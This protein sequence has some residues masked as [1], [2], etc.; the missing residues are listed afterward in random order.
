L[1]AI[2]PYDE[3][4]HEK[5]RNVSLQRVVVTGTFEFVES[6]SPIR[7]V[8][9][10]VAVITSK[11]TA[12][13][14][15]ATGVVLLAA[16]NSVAG[17]ANTAQGSWPYPNGNLANTRVATDSAISIANVRTL[18]KVWSFRITGK[19]AKSL[20]HLGSLAATP[21]VVNGVVYIQDLYSNV[22]ALSLANGTLLWKYYV[23][24]PELSGPGP[25][26]VAVANGAVYGF[27]PTHAF[28][29]NAVNGHVLWVD[30]H[31]LKKGQ[32]T[33]G[34]QPTVANGTLYAASQYGFAP[35]G[36]ILLALNASNGH[37]LWTFN[38]VKT[39]DPGVIS[40]GLGAGG[41]W[42]TPLVGT[43]GSVTFGT[44]NPYQYLSNAIDQPQKQLYTDSEVNLNAKTGKLRWCFQ[45]E[46]NDFKDFD[47]QT[48]PI[49][50]SVAN[51][52]VI[53]ASGKMGIVYEM[54]ARTGALLWKRA[55]GVHNGHDNDSLNLLL[56][57]GTLKVPFTY[58][59]G[60]L[61]GVLTNLAVAGNSVYVDTINLALRFTSTSQV[62]GVPPKGVTESGEVESLNLTTGKVQWDDK[63]SKLPLGAATVVNNLLITTLYTGQLLAINRAT[64]A[65]V[66]KLTL[67]TTTNSALAIAGNTIIVPLGGLKSGK[68]QG[69]SPQ[70]VAYRLP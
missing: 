24:K 23:N 49:S 11:R 22:Y 54:N 44:G 67:P 10:G 32:G 69:G 62:V 42:E 38:T 60:S 25:N 37:L 4:A 68:G 56:H 53:L 45:A 31:L 5:N 6:A 28:A 70:I 61:G 66:Y 19:A 59:P 47:L 8:A 13:R 34:I 16:S 43:D 55:V 15:M 2:R 65:I 3:V 64:G 46:Q 1:Q 39:P 29:L 21:V 9:G 18:R 36:G 33:F 17:A 30:K 52:P 20:Q 58:E 48:S 7:D 27:T 40:L 41:A 57:K 63:V 14:A 50:T 26:G 51:R 12:I 35:G